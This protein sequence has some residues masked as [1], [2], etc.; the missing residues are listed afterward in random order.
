[1]GPY[2]GE[3]SF[4]FA[5]GPQYSG[6]GGSPGHQPFYSM[7]NNFGM[8]EERAVFTIQEERR[9]KFHSARLAELYGTN[10]LA[11]RVGRE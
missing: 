8:N 11:N 2:T 4:G 3:E 5:L 6:N 1:M 7:K 10:D 9:L